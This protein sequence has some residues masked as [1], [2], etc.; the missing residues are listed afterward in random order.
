MWLWTA[1][2]NVESRGADV[3]KAMLGADR[4]KVVISDRCM[5]CAQ[6]K[7]RQVCPPHLLRDSRASIDWGGEAGGVGRRLLDRSDALS[8]CWHQVRDGTLARSSFRLSVSRMRG[9]L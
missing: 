9:S 4:R 6:V 1:I 8:R 5:S 3:A 2:T 7:R